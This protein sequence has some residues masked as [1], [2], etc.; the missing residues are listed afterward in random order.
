MAERTTIPEDTR[1]DPAAVA[2]DPGASPAED[3]AVRPPDGLPETVPRPVRTLIWQARLGMAVGILGIAL[4]LASMLYAQ[5]LRSD[6]A[7]RAAVLDAGEVIALR[8]T[9]Y[10]GGAIDDWVTDTQSLSTGEY[11][12]EVASLFDPDIRAGLAEAEVE[13]VGEVISSFVQDI[14]GD[15]ATVFAVLRQTYQSNVSPRPTSDELRMEIQLTRVDGEWLA[16]DVAVLGP[17]ALSTVE[18]TGT[19]P[20]STEEGG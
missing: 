10:E 12:R 19:T 13:S 7:T 3:D 2:A 14:N 1:E 18:D 11:A 17:S 6:A 15:A 16:S 8:V 9:T 20:D 5:G 4:A